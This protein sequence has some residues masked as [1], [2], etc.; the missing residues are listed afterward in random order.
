MPRPYR[1]SQI[2]FLHAS[3][4]VRGHGVAYLGDLIRDSRRGSDERAAHQAF[5]AINPV[6]TR[7]VAN[8]VLTTIIARCPTLL[9]SSILSLIS[10]V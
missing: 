8:V 5:Q 2:D 6:E 7:L 4:P 3:V 1:S 10:P 9:G